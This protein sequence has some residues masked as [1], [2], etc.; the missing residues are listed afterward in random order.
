MN[1]LQNIYDKLNSKTE[2]AKHEVE[3][4]LIS[5]LQKFNAEA[6]IHLAAFRKSQ[7]DLK[8]TAKIVV[9]SGE[10]FKS[11]LS[12][13]NDTARKISASFKE[14]GLDYQANADIKESQKILNE[15]FDVADYVIYTK[16]IVSK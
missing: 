12:D 3:L 4:S 8:A 1:T 5:E 13:I 2:L 14:L 10:N 15:N 16:Q 11:N 6:K 7:A 9:A